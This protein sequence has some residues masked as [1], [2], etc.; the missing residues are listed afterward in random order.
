M[1]KQ[2]SIICPIYNEKN[3]IQQ[4]IDSLLLQDYSIQNMEI[5]LIDGMSTD[6]TREIIVENIK[7]HPKIRLIDNPDKTVPQALNKG[8]R[9]SKGEIIFR[10]DA[11]SEYPTNYISLLSSKLIEL[12]AGNIGGRLVTV[13]GSNKLISKA[14]AL[15]MSHPFGVGNAQFRLQTKGIIEVDTVPFG[16][17]KREIFDKIG[18]FDEDLIRNQDFHLNARIIES[19]KKIYLISDLVLK[20]VSRRN[21]KLIFKMYY[22]YGLFNPLMNK[23]LNKPAAIRQFIPLFFVLFLLGGILLSLITPVLLPF[24]LTV[25]GIY[26]FLS[27]SVSLRISFKEKN[28]MYSILLP[29][30][31]FYIHFSYGWGYFV[32][33]IYMLLNKNMKIGISR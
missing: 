6:G 15:A 2:I 9:E 22:Q 14:I 24:Y 26:L 25:L 19:G 16:C 18:F 29:I 28:I 7:L 3:N 23:K 8:I 5:L 32:G 20:Y 11:H 30:V 12:D 4:C 21:L 31:F 10:V 17:F 1:Y 33:L 27:L 13:P